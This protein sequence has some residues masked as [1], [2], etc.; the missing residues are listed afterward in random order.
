[1][2]KDKKW[3]VYIHISPSNK[4]YIGITSQTAE[5]RW[6][7]G[8]GYK[9]CVKFFKAIQ[10]YG[11]ENF[12][13]II[14]FENLSREIANEI[15]KYLIAKYDTIDNGYNIT[16]GGYTSNPKLPKEE[17]RRNSKRNKKIYRYN[18]D[19]EY[20]DEFFSISE[21]ER[22]TSILGSSIGN[23]AKGKLLHAGGYMWRY[24]YYKKISPYINPKEK[25]VCLYDLSKKLI[26]E[27]KSVKNASFYSGYTEQEISKCCKRKI[28]TLDE[29][30]FLYKGDDINNVEIQNTYYKGYIS[31]MKT[32]YQY[33]FTKGLINSFDSLS[34]AAE[35]TGDSIS[36]ISSHCK[37]ETSMSTKH[38]YYTFDKNGNKNMKQ[39]SN[40]NKK[41]ICQIHKNGEIAN[42]F[43]SITKASNYT[44]ININC[45][46]GV[47][48]GRCKTAGGYGWKYKDEIE[49]IE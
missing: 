43:D 35:K 23:C 7:K 1:M 29:N 3:L 28:E 47:L 40:H 30:I 49:I 38:Y 46:V 18:L 2:I 34:D 14:L 22:V 13:H 44:G 4:Y 10:K 8:K 15:E 9:T 36:M 39:Y 37:N 31:L 5:Q 17:L 6:R 42:I 25:E 48:K 11:W 27:F 20:I 45:I 26:K 19:G 33:S 12:E 41:E 21:A 24:K 32:V 16:E